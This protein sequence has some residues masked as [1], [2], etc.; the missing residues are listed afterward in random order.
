MPAILAHPDAHKLLPWMPAILA[1]AD[2]RILLPWMPANLAHAEGGDFTNSVYRT[3]LA[4]HCHFLLPHLHASLDLLPSSYYF[5]DPRFTS[6][7]HFTPN[8]LVSAAHLGSSSHRSGPLSGPGPLRGLHPNSY[9]CKHSH[10]GC[11]TIA[12][13][14]VAFQMLLRVL[15]TSVW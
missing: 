11:G 2:A 10:T 8:V 6:L 3:F 1:H 14:E 5:G 15:L 7:C 9:Q 12:P 4:S 13:R